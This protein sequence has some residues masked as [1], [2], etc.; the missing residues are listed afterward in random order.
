MDFKLAQR[1]RLAGAG[2]FRRK[3]QPHPCSPLAGYLI[4]GVTELD[5]SA[6]LFQDLAHDRE[7]QTCAFFPCGDI[8][9]KESAA[10]LFRQTDP[11]V[12]HLDDN[13]GAVSHDRDI[14]P[15]GLLL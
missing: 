15:A 10:V 1:L 2:G 11:V 14:D 5:A 9:L 7:T 4:G 12:G 13:V 3:A 6:V 8:R